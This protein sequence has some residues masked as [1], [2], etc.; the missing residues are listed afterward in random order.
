MDPSIYCFP[1]RSAFGEMRND[2]ACRRLTAP[3]MFLQDM[4]DME[5]GEPLA[6]VVSHREA[7]S[8]SK[9]FFSF[10]FS[11]QDNVRATL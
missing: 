7:L 9:W 8:D 3:N 5:E 11:I 6:R 10:R 1:E 4:E 2:L